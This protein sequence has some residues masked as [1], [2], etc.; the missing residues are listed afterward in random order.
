MLKRIFRTTL[1]LVSTITFF[2]C[3]NTVSG[4]SRI[5]YT[6]P[7]HIKISGDELKQSGS[8]LVTDPKSRYHAEIVIYSYSSGTESI[9]F[10]GE[11]MSSSTGEGRIR[12]LVKIM[13]G[14]SIIKAVFI[15]GRGK[16]REEMI[17][18]LFNDAAIKLKN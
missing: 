7:G 4:F 8:V 1:C 12:G 16:K 9:S 17:S 3:D 14:K 13:D 5:E 15:E 11:E 2:S 10:S 6:I 18:S